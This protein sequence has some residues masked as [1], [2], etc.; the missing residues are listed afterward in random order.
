MQPWQ[1][2]AVLDGLKSFIPLQR[3]LR[4]A[5][6]A[7]KP[8]QTN[9]DNDACLIADAVNQIKQLH[10]LGYSVEGK[11]VV[12]I[13][14]GWKPVLPLI[15]NMCGAAKIT[16]V[17]QERLLDAHTFRSA[18]DFVTS[19]TSITKGLNGAIKVPHLGSARGHGLELESLLKDYL[20]DYRAPFRFQDL[21]T[22][23]ADLIVSRDVLEHV[24]E[25]LLWTIFQESQRILR[26][27][28]LLCHTIDVSDHWE[29]KDKSISKVNFLRYEGPLWGLAGLNPQNFQNRL[30]RSEYVAML[31]R[32]GFRVLMATG[33][34]DQ[35]SMDALRSMELCRRYAELPH[36]ELAVLYTTIIAK[37][38]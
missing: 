21:A 22:N 29:H 1:R 15:Y 18:I 7:L 5:Y 12:E 27:G 37:A 38:D 34:P 4:A 35:S 19:S 14:T 31:E 20:I 16:T 23:S 3:P 13:G 33:A 10:E 28:G 11:S 36:E 9:S 24:P 30:R 25:D 8:Y 6:R 2:K 32:V 17:D 26:P